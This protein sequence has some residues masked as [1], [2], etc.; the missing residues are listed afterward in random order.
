MTENARIAAALRP[1]QPGD[2]CALISPS[3][4]SEEEAIAKGEDL[5]RSWG[6]VPVRAPHVADRHARADYLAGAD[7]DRAADLTWA[8]TDPEISGVFCV[9][10]GYGAIRVLDHLDPEALAAATP[11][12][13]FGSSDITALHEYW[14]QHVGVPTW[15]TPMIATGDLL[16]SPEN[17]DALRRAVL[18]DGPLEVAS[19]PETATLVPGVAHGELT[20][21]NVSL[22][23]MSTGSHPGTRTRAEGRIVLLEEI[24]ESAYRLDALMQILLRSGYF[25]G[26]AAVGLGTWVDCG[27]IEDI[28]ALMEELLSPLGIPVV[29]GLRFGHGARVSSFPI[30]CGLTATLTADDQPQL[31]F[32]RVDARSA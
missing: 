11:K 24:H 6:L 10:G 31:V 1:L 5:L 12:P 26:A 7:E 17:V 9:R 13:L 21:G 2:R 19:D 15:F 20:G 14:Q 28:R 30:G 3:G 22:L 23:A 8:W 4:A 25:D 27:P 18:G 16:N 29:W 32:D